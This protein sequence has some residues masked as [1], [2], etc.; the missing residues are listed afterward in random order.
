MKL[1]N[2]FLAFVVVLL[3]SACAKKSMS[4][5]GDWIV[6][7]VIQKIQ[8]DRM[9]AAKLWAVKHKYFEIRERLKKERDGHFNEMLSLVKAGDISLPEIKEHIDN[10]RKISDKYLT[11]IFPLVKDLH[12]SLSKK[13][14]EEITTWAVELRKR[15]DL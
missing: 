4:E 10:G 14:K 15:F 12:S 13:Q 11:E 8:L 9:Q 7:K 1:I 2:I 3:F 5:R 6:K